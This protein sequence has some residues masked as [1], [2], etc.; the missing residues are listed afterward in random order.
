MESVLCF[1]QCGVWPS[2]HLH[3]FERRNLKRQQV[4]LFDDLSTFPTQNRFP[5]ASKNGTLF[6]IFV[7]NRHSEQALLE[8]DDGG[9][10]PTHGHSSHGGAGSKNS[11]LAAGYS[12]RRATVRLA[13]KSRENLKRHP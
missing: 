13:Q 4:T 10:K 11:W 7:H 3:F 8:F 2:G 5:R 1:E 9:N 6:D 12:E